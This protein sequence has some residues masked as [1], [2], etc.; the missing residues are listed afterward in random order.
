[1]A[2]SRTVKAEK[3][4]ASYRIQS[5]TENLDE[6]PYS[7][8]VVYSDKLNEQKG[9]TLQRNLRKEQTLLEK[10]IEKFE[11]TTYHC[12]SDAEEAWE[13]FQNAHKSHYFHYSCT[14]QRRTNGKTNK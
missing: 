12:E 9:Q 6:Y 5:F 11:K 1:M 4:A 14:I 13:A 10:A 8:V 7:F 2:R 3:K